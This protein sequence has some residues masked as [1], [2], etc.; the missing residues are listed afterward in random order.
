MTDL[1]DADNLMLVAKGAIGSV[2]Q[3]VWDIVEAS[4]P[5]QARDDNGEYTHVHQIIVVRERKHG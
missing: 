5:Y 2:D 4:P 1:T 3:P